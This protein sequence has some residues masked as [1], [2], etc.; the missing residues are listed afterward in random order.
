MATKAIPQLTEMW[1]K[2]SKNGKWEVA[3][4]PPNKNKGFESLT[5]SQRQ[6]RE[7]A[8]REQLQCFPDN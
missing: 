7:T 6:P 4:Y 3:L 8:T 1:Q 5:A 2:G